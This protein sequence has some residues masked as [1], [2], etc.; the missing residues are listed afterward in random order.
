MAGANRSVVRVEKITAGGAQKN[1][2]HN[3][4]KNESYANL[5]V[6]LERTPLNIHYKDTN[7]LTYN[8]YFQ[9][10]IDEG[11]IST[12]GQK[13]GATI[14]NELIIDVNTRYFEEHGGYEYAREF[15]EEAYRF[16]CGVY[17]EENIVS[18]VMHADE[19]NKAVSEK[20]GKPVYHYHLHV[21][22]IPTVEKEIRWSKRCKDE[23][24]RGTVKE[25]IQQVSHSKKWK[26]TVP[27][28]D[29]KGQQII[30]KYGKPVFRKSY[31][32]LQDRLFEHMTE[33]GYKDF[34]RGE[35]GSTAENLSSLEYQITQD[36]KRLSEV[37][38]EVKEARTSLAEVKKEVK[39]QQKISAT[40]GEIDALGNKTM[41]GKYTV[42]KKELDNLKV[43]AKEGVSSRA[44]IHDLQ[45]T[46]S[47]YQRQ[48]MELSSRLTHVK[49]KLQEVTKKYEQLVEV[50]KP[51][52]IGLQRFPERVKEFF[53]KLF[54]PKEWAE[55]KEQ[56]MPHRKPKR[57]DDWER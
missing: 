22:A 36:K 16:C 39:V 54:P 3:E 4:R 48:T 2:R 50:T 47:Y 34:E 45:Q 18:A 43:L 40:Y 44:E 8:E 17:G 32:V 46:L 53:E 49:E 37:K 55:E 19:I 28:L 25:V 9:K 30:S 27:L 6:E 42:S 26:N 13:E 10:L 21:V 41:T 38:Q 14:F 35:L 20:M 23:A 24:L 12:R 7:G 29:E 11:K 31:S 51:Y 33:A 15:Y 56:P 5:N 57:R 1:E 52:L